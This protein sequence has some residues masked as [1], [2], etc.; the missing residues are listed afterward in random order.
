MR[1]LLLPL[2]FLYHAGVAVRNWCF[3]H[4]WLPTT[5]VNVPV[6]SVGNI[7]AGGVG[8]TPLVEFL[9]RRLTERGKLVAVLSRGYGRAT[10]GTLVVSNGFVQ[11]AAADEAGDEPAQMAAKLS[12]VVVVVDEDR[13]RGARYAIERFRVDSILLDDGFQHRYLHRDLDLVI[14]PYDEIGQ[15]MVLLP[16]GDYREP[17]SALRRCDIVVI[18][19]CSSLEDALRSREILR[20]RLEKPVVAFAL[21]VRAVRRAATRFSVDLNGLV[22]KRIVA[23]SGI[24]NPDS[25]DRTLHSLKWEVV[26]H[27][28]FADHHRYSREELE[29]LKR[30][31]TELKAD[32][33]VTT[34]KDVARLIG[35]QNGAR[36][37][38][39]QMPLYYVE[40]EQSVLMGEGELEEVLTKLLHRSVEQK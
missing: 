12:G 16:A 4:R 11:C 13:V 32:Y 7:K 23:F 20:Q 30:E 24:G 29:G 33:L 27:R 26:Q 19:R 1:E 38:L 25:F 3:D 21:R 22:G 8:K 5:E 10:S 39:E 15:K 37:L 34:E 36:Q 28:R 18:T 6:I 2:S 40:V 35:A 17:F 14:L 9:A 31:F